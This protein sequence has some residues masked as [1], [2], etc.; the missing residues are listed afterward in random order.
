MSGGRNQGPGARPA[1][2]RSDQG[3]KGD[4]SR[5]WVWY[6]NF[7]D[8]YGPDQ[9]CH[10]SWMVSHRGSNLPHKVAIRC[11]TRMARFSYFSI[12]LY[13]SSYWLEITQDEEILLFSCW[14]VFSL[15]QS[16]DHQRDAL[17][18]SSLLH[19]LVHLIQHGCHCRYSTFLLIWINRK[20]EV[21]FAR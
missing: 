9:F 10:T 4:Q 21:A 12:L 17:S 16:L 2:A 20:I 13:T 18:S 15:R 8:G 5:Q 7:S 14:S 6:L 3:R 11:I 1:A 19:S